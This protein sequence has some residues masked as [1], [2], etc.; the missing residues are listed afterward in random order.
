MCLLWLLG[1][2]L[3]DWQCFQIFSQSRPPAPTLIR[4]LLLLSL[5]LRPRSGGGSPRENWAARP[6]AHVR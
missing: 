5:L 4:Q 6:L 1:H 2:F 3:F